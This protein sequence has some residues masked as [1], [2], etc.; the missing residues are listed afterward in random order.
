MT[1]LFHLAD[2]ICNKPLLVHP[3][4]VPIILAALQ[5]RLPIAA[6]PDDP[7]DVDLAQTGREILRGPNANQFIGRN[8][9]QGTRSGRPYRV[10]Q[11]VAIISI[12]G[13]LVNRGA[14]IGA[15]SGLVSY[16]GLNHQL[17]AAAADSKV[18]SILLDIESPGGEAVGC[19]ETAELVQQISL[20]KP[21]VALVNGM[22]ASAAYAIA[23]AA[24]KIVTIPTGIS[25][26]IG[27][28]LL[29]LDFSQHLAD[30]GIKPTFI[31]AGAHKVDGNMYEPLPEGVR[32]GMQADIDAFYNMFVGTVA[33]GR[34]GQMTEKAVRS[35][36]A[37]TYMGQEAVR[38]GLADEVGTFESTLASLISPSP[39]PP[40]KN[41]KLLEGKPFP[42]TFSDIPPI[43]R[44]GGWEEWS[45]AVAE[46]QEIKRLVNENNAA[47]EA[48]AVPRQR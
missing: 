22:A 27:V 42:K 17:R 36:E 16:E 18:N 30:E 35:T 28:V 8:Y 9:D 11:D 39:A 43:G 41:F 2:R 48:R 14:W 10:S 26:S 33:K 25:G 6:M 29:H 7:I 40:Q 1:Q 15:Y 45:A 24:T 4:K 19:F 37:R 20:T 21:V 3:D 31:H 13:S 5:G 44:T 38:I 23:S 34:K 47:A 12:I 46:R 32:E